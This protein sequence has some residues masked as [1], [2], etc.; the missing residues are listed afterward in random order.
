[1]KIKLFALT[2]LLFLFAMNLHSQTESFI[3]LSFGA[4]L[5]QGDF[6]SS[7]FDMDGSGY[8]TTGFVV[9]FDAALFPDEYLGFGATV[10]FING[11]IDK[12]KYK[13]DYL[14][15]IYDEYGED[16]SEKE[17]FY[18][19]M[20]V[21]RVINLMVG[22]TGTINTGSFNFDVRALIGA[23]FVFP[24]GTE[25]QFKL[26]NGREFNTFREKKASIGF[27]YDLGVGIRYAMKSG[28]VLRFTADYSGTKVNFDINDEIKY[29]NG[30][31]EMIT[32]SVDFPISNIQLGIGI[33]YNFEL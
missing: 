15:Y 28:Y 20:E 29:D 16:L 14:Q 10:T 18:F 4:A 6:A 32:R 13:E 33:A 1:M 3:G 17:D 21:W 25:I 30:D 2:I 27:G 22:P 11:N 24:P 9:G 7:D 8:A 12:K 5:P 31:V 23:S 26:D 19:D